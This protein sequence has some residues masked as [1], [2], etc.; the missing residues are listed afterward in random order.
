[1]SSPLLAAKCT[2][3]YGSSSVL[4]SVRVQKVCDISLYLQLWL[5]WEQRRTD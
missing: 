4:L 2:M 5:T 1:M 3:F